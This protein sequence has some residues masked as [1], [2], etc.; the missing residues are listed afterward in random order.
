MTLWSAPI[1]LPPGKRNKQENGSPAAGMYNVA[2]DLNVATQQASLHLI[3]QVR[4]CGSLCLWC[5]SC[6][7]VKESIYQFA[8]PCENI[9][10]LARRFTPESSQKARA[11][12]Q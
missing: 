2:T 4:P 11:K 5:G 8:N 7:T 6:L 3:T 12:E 1:D 10:W 9:A